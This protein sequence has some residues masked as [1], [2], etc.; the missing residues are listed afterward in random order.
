MKLFYFLTNVS[1]FL[2]ECTLHRSILKSACHISPYEYMLNDRMDK[3][4]SNR[5]NLAVFLDIFN[6]K[7]EW[8]ERGNS[9]FELLIPIGQFPLTLSYTLLQL[10]LIF[11]NTLHKLCL[12]ST[13]PRMSALHF[14][15]F[16]VVLL[17]HFYLCSQ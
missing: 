17:L 15:C 10:L 3:W 11:L 7:E 6:H 2:V 13:Y 16:L 1:L 5:T 8:M 9:C 12:I 14:Y 4:T